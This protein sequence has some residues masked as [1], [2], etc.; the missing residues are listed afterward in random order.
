M[1][2]SWT[3]WSHIID[4]L[5]KTRKCIKALTKICMNKEK[6]PSLKGS[7]SNDKTEEKK[8]HIRQTNT[9]M[10]ILFIHFC[11]FCWHS[12]K[13]LSLCLSLLNKENKRETD[14]VEISLLHKLYRTNIVCMR[15]YVALIIVISFELL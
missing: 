4:V 6:I 14:R 5:M 3:Y 7:S 15:A 11:W 13:H 2:V 8:A 9:P 12:E 10:G 1:C